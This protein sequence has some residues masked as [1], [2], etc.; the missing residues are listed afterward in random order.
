MLSRPMKIFPLTI[1]FMYSS[2]GKLSHFSKVIISK[3]NVGMAGGGVCVTENIVYKSY[4]AMHTLKFSLLLRN[5]KQRHFSS[6]KKMKKCLPFEKLKVLQIWL[7]INT[8][9]IHDV[10]LFWAW[11]VLHLAISLAKL[12]FSSPPHFICRLLHLA[13]KHT[14]VYAKLFYFM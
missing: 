10:I 8:W 3:L 9:I 13:Q 12:F 5:I 4:T 11:W 14:L 2:W 1:Y 7:K 6:G